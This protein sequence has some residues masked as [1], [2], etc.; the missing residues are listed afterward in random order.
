MRLYHYAPKTNTILQNGLY[1]YAK[2]PHL[3]RSYAVPAKSDKKKDIIAWMEN[4]IFPGRSKA[5]SCLTEPMQWRNNDPVL[6][7]IVKS[8]TLFSFELDDLLKAGLVEAIWCRDD[9]A[10][11]GHKYVID[12]HAQYFYEVK[13]E[14]I[15]TSPLTWGKVDPSKKLMYGAVRHYMVV[16]KKGIIPPEYLRPEKNNLG[17]FYNL[18]Q[19][20]KKLFTHKK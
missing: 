15:D 1:S 5:I 13:P 4:N 12:K 19:S 9:L 2:H 8:S 14:E 3:Q 11:K 16:M 17:F 7:K 6:K 18:L 10:C 20:V